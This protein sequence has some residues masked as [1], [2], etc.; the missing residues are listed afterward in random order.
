[1]KSDE[2]SSDRSKHSALRILQE[3]CGR[4]RLSWPKS[5]TRTTIEQLL[6]ERSDVDPAELFRLLLETE[7][8]L[9]CT[10]GEEPTLAEYQERFPPYQS[11]INQVFSGIGTQRD[12]SPHLHRPQPLIDGISSFEQTVDEL[13]ELSEM[14]HP[15]SRIG[16]YRVK[17]RL[18]HG[19]FGIVYLAEDEKLERLVAIKMPHRR[20]VMNAE[21]VETYLNEARSVAKLDHPHIV[22]VF[23]VGSDEACPCYVVSKYIDGSNL[24]SR[25]KQSRL[26]M[27]ETVE[28]VMTLAEAL[29]YSHKQGLVHRDVKPGN[30]LLDTSNK[31]YLADFGLALREQ[32]IG[33][34]A[35]FAGTPMYMSPEQARGE[36]HRVDGRSDI[37]SLGVVFYE[38][39]TGRRPF[40]ADTQEALL[41]QITSD[42]ARP[43]RQI[44]DSIPKELE[45]ICLKSLSKRAAERHTTAKDLA[46]DLREFLTEKARTLSNQFKEVPAEQSPLTLNPSG[47][48]SRS[49]TS[50]ASGASAIKI[51]PKGLRSFDGGDADFFLDLLPG[52]RDRTGLPDSLRFWKT[53]IEA[54]DTDHSFMVG[55]I[56]G[57]SGCGKSSLVKAGLLPRLSPDVI[58][59]YIEATAEDTET[60]LLNGLRKKCPNLNDQLGLKESIAALRRGQGIPA[61]KKVLIV[62]DQF[63]QWLHARK[64]EDHT[65]LLQALRHCDGSR[66]QCIVMVRDDF[67]LA[68]SRF[69]RNLEVELDANRN[70][71]LVD[72]FDLDHARKVLAALGR[73]FGKLPDNAAETTKEQKEFLKRAVSELAQEN[74]VI[75]VRLALFAEMMK[76]RP[77]TLASL[78]DVGGTQGI[79]ITFLEDTFSSAIANPAHRI[80]Q[81]AARAVLKTLLPETGQAIK[82]N[83]RSRSDLLT[84]SGYA[85][86]PRDF[87]DLM[88]IL[89]SDV[90]LLTPTDP[91][92]SEPVDGAT[93]QN[94]AGQKYYQ[95]THDFMVH[96]L[97]DWL[98]RKQ[99]ETRQGRAELRLTERAALFSDKPENRYLPSLDE[100]ARFRLYTRS[101]D[102]T[103]PQR[104]MMRQADIYYCL[105]SVMLL[106]VCFL[107]GWGVTELSAQY[108]VRMLH[109]SLLRAD[110]PGASKIISE[111]EPYRSR[112]QPLLAAELAQTTDPTRKLV[113]SLALVLGDPSQVPFLL[114]QLLQAAPAEFMVIRQQLAPYQ[115]TI[116]DGLWKELGKTDQGV[117]K[118]FRAACALALYDTKSERWKPFNEFIVDQLLTE[119]P[120]YL[121]YWKEAL[122]PV[123][124]ELLPVLADKLEEN[125]GGIAERRSI[126]EFY[127]SFAAG[128]SSG[129]KLLETRLGQDHPELAG[130]EKGQRQ[131]NV[132]SALAALGK[133]ELVWP[134]LVHTPNPTTRSFLIER[135]GT[136]Q[137][138]LKI[139]IDQLLVEKEVS[140]RRALLLS[141]GQFPAANYQSV[142]SL[143]LLEWYENDPDPG[144]HACVGWL[145]RQWGRQKEVS[146]IE[147]KLATGEPV[148]NRQWYINKQGQT[149][150]V[151]EGPASLLNTQPSG[152]PFLKHRYAM[153]VTEVTVAQFKKFRPDHKYDEKISPTPDSPINKVSWYDAAAY[154]DWLSKEEGILDA[155]QWCY[156]LKDEKLEFE[157]NYQLKTGYRL[158]TEQEWEFANKTGAR[159]AGSFGDGNE[160][161]TGRY[162]CCFHNSSVN[163]ERRCFPVALLKPN[164]WGLFDMH[165]NV[166][167]WCQETTIVSE[168]LP[169]NDVISVRRGTSYLAEFRRVALNQRVEGGRKQ[170]SDSTGFRIVRSIP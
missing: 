26:S 42:E 68:V 63:E 21:D 161:L 71:L 39:L 12:V 141:L 140:R 61:G 50:A 7:I 81:K 157:K 150:S 95:L 159:T 84:A 126:I 108:Q 156:E 46:D 119:N 96:S 134:L 49:A 116:T 45:R 69:M 6:Q 59:I 133:P 158:P 106:I 13:P 129:V 52:P 86:Q 64:D 58:S 102:W 138:D 109:A 74:R 28:L 167:E 100:Y 83:M 103:I 23:D 155:K 89:D 47:V 76:N 127:R 147:A 66:L 14:G 67:W 80:H 48:Q 20:L 30:I 136:Y 78:R 148:G 32:D 18:G 143:P 151:I 91:A 166:S 131:A 70:I 165:G 135:L 44:D 2:V 110:V 24:A 55:L 65:E 153:G 137:V 97:R 122:H 98:T 51:V 36:G 27:K 117:E 73:A 111:M 112:L 85:Q 93:V 154:C 17:K 92:G 8:E 123:R 19:G 115:S 125:K 15:P 121:S 130:A 120:L 11:I 31:P 82:G 38:L 57:P 62:L 75:S 40:K 22:P 53:R 90:R 105:R 170:S 168:L 118:R 162:A 72:L 139:I 33:K 113:L 142:S 35:R 43:P 25:L 29:H 144:I 37:F 87:D 5:E 146:Q 164:D 145:L 163:G 34:G 60:R 56:Y 41:E 128:E 104:R 9:R 107:V 149:L 99:R 16:R 1:M 169:F 94:E 114:E 88:K 132:A 101:K 3:I 4:F 124:Q 10:A 79:G 77:W 160:E 54:I 152:T